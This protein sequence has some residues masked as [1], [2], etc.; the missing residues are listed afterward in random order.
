MATEKGL[1]ERKKEQTREALSWAAIRLTV[2]RGFDNVLVED[3][4]AAAGVSART[5]NNYFSSKAEAIAARHADRGRRIAAELLA[6]PADEPLWT[7]ITEAV[8]AGFTGAP[9]GQT[10]PGPQWRKQVPIMLDSPAL[11][12]EFLRANAAVEADI[13]AAISARTGIDSG[14]LYPKLLAG[15]VGAAILAVLDHWRQAED[16]PPVAELLR[17][18]F[19]L[20]AQ[21]PPTR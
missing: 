21:G 2:E 14:Q 18:A 5:F 4:A 9:G 7:A 15:T 19:G 16:P 6:R 17:E 1:R 11:Q 3:I 12:G 20:L 8:V 13:L 10:D